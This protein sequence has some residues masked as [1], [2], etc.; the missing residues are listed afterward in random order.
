[1]TPERQSL[2]A[3]LKALL[4]EIETTNRPPAAAPAPAAPR[5]ATIVYK[6]LSVIDT[7]RDTT[8]VLDRLVA[9][10][11]VSIGRYISAIAPKAEKTVKEPEARAIA[12]KGLRLFLICE[13]WGDFAH[14]AISAA[15]GERDG[16]FCRDYAARV[17]APASAIIYFAVDIDP[18]AAEIA[19]FVLPYFRAIQAAMG[20]RFRVGVYGSGAV[21]RAV[22]AAGLAIASWV[23]GSSAWLGSRE[24]LAEG[25]QTLRQYPPGHDRGIRDNHLDHDANDVNLGRPIGDFVPFA[26][27]A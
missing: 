26:Q 25:L 6:P 4:E 23:S 14:G 10:G 9:S 2:F 3:R 7:N 12:G 22:T 11:V 17:G 16:A 19:K 18:T 24:Y 8:A 15:A 20:G 5:P 1:V 21:C 13:G 27:A